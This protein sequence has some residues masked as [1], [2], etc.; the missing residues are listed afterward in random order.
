MKICFVHPTDIEENNDSITNYIRGIIE[1]AYLKKDDIIYI[2]ILKKNRIKKRKKNS[3]IKCR[4]FTWGK[5]AEKRLF[6][7]TLKYMILLYIF[8]IK[9][10]NLFKGRIISINQIEWALPFL[11]P[12]KS[13]P[14]VITIHG[15]H[16]VSAFLKRK[17][18]ITFYGRIKTFIYNH[19]ER[20]VINKV[21]KVIIISQERYNFYISKYPNN[22]KKFIF[23][24]PFIDS[25]KFFYRKNKKY[26]REKYGLLKDDIVLLYIGRIVKEKN[27]DLVVKSFKNL[28][29]MKNSK[30][31]KLLLVGNGIF[32]EKIETIINDE[33][34]ENVFLMNEMSHNLI[35]EI[36]NCANV[37]ILVSSFEGTPISV[38]EVLSCGIPVVA[39]KVGDLPKLIFNGVNGYLINNFSELE[40]INAINY[41]MKIKPEPYK[42]VESAKEYWASNVIPIILKEYSKTFFGIKKVNK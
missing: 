15:F 39:S 23:I 33:K 12:I 4:F 41:I 40:L 31:L 5:Q 1:Y 8:I 35:P 30:N 38:L 42:C 29:K 24:P 14:V 27:I 37:F 7:I 6:P 3:S 19:L 32:K 18:N 20:F 21:D 16:G 11:Y 28:N 36:I 2:G 26:L 10:K 22:C 25:Q 13:N 34:I 9:N 17:E